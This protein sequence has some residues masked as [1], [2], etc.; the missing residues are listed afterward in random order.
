MAT[1]KE[2]CCIC[3]GLTDRAGKADDSI[4][5]CDGALGPL[6][7]ECNSQ[8]DKEAR[9]TL[10]RDCIALIGKWQTRATCD[11]YVAELARVIFD[12]E[13]EPARSTRLG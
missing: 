4:Y 1:E 12:L 9:I 5:R 2:H 11:C 3:D 10:R 7:E 13:S 8:M 6:C